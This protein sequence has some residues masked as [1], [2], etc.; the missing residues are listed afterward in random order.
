M[1]VY[2][3]SN[4]LKKVYLGNTEIKKIYVGDNLV[5]VWEDSID[6]YQKVQ[7]IEFTGT[8]Y[9]D[10]GF[11]VG[12]SNF[13]GSPWKWFRMDA[14]F[15]ATYSSQACGKN[16]G[17]ALFFWVNSSNYFYA[18]IWANWWRTDTAVSNNWAKHNFMIMS[19]GYVWIDNTWYSIDTWSW[20]TFSEEIPLNVYI[21]WVSNTD[22]NKFLCKMKLYSY[23]LYRGWREDLIPCYHKITWEV[24]LFNSVEKKFLRNSGTGTILKWPDVN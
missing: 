16:K 9:I 10:T 18:W 11:S 19:Y 4:E 12:G 15:T 6:N 23:T 13:P 21:W 22:A 2:L 7:Y 20:G 1:I 14:S 24:W 5:Y 17:N 8:Q 3:G